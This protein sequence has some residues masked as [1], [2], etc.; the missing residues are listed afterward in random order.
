MEELRR[1]LLVAQVRAELARVLGW[2][3]QAHRV[4]GYDLVYELSWKRADAVCVLLPE[5]ASDL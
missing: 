3:R 1:A 2:Y 4:R 5:T